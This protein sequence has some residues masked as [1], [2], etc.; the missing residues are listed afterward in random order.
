MDRFAKYLALRG[1]AVGQTGELELVTRLHL[2]DGTTQEIINMRRAVCKKAARKGNITMLT[3]ADIDTDALQRV[4]PFEQFTVADFPGLFE[5]HVGWYI[6]QGVGTVVKMPLAWISSAGGTYSYA[7]CKILDPLNPPTVLAVYRGSQP[8]QGAVVSSAEYTTGS[9]TGAATGVKV[10][11][12]NFTREQKDFGGRPYVVEADLL[13]PGSRAPSDEISRILGLYGLAVDSTTFTAAA[14]AD[15]AAGFAIDALYGARTKGRTGLAIINDLL[16]VARGWLSITAAGAWAIV[17]DV[18]K[19]SSAQFDTAADLIE[20]AEYG[21]GDIDKTVTLD[22]R[23]KRSGEEEYAASLSRT[24]AG[25]AGERRIRCPYIRDH[26]VADRLLSY[27]QKRL[28]TLRVASGTIYATQQANGDRISVTDSTN[29]TGTKDFILTGISRPADSNSV[30][31]REYDASIYAYTA[32]TLPSDAT[33]VYTPDFSYT[34]PLAPASVG[35]SS[36]GVSADNDGKQTAFAFFTV[37]P[38]AN[39]N[40]AKLTVQL[41]DTTT[42]ELYQ[43]QA[44]FVSPGVYSVSIGGLRPNRL[45]S[46]SAWATNANNL[47]GA[48]ATAANFTTASASIALAAPVISVAQ[49]T[50]FFVDLDQSAIADVAGSPKFRRYVLFEKIGAGAFV[51]KMRTADRQVHLAVQHGNA[52]QWK[53]HAEDL[54]GNETADSNTV[55]LTPVAV[56]DD[57]HIV[58]TGVGTNSLANSAVSQGKANTSVGS[59]TG[60]A[61]PGINQWGGLEFSFWINGG[62]NGQNSKL[63]TAAGAPGSSQAVYLVDNLTLTA[64]FALAFRAFNP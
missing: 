44:A 35:L 55:S 59:T 21:D 10:L 5:D 17:Q 9:T 53:A 61:S 64:P 28:N 24:T 47:D 50:S 22:Y 39:S 43:A 58:P 14:V 16:N 36:T 63:V 42:N 6:P 34:A 41:K 62:V 56:I 7:G 48:I 25:G 8:G 29:W 3:F 37:A 19:A 46:V 23:P 51:E 4:F 1:N 33:N 30:K 52:Y 20:I 32:G 18:A 45:H 40:W 27:W 31:L 54:V 13:I 15:T 57:T 38:P 12:V 26:L 49:K 11:S 60:T 2:A